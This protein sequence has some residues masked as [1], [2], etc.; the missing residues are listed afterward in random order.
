MSL[1][2]KVLGGE[3]NQDPKPFAFNTS[4]GIYQISQCQQLA[5]MK[6]FDLKLPIERS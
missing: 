5:A 4:S 2:R 1:E 6:E 3:S